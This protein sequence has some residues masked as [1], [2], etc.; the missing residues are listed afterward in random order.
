MGLSYPP[1]AC[2]MGHTALLL[3]PRHFRH[4]EVT[5]Q[6]ARL[7]THTPRQ[8]HARGFP[9]SRFSIRNVLSFRGVLAAEPVS[10]TSHKSAARSGDDNGVDGIPVT[11]K[12]NP[13]DF[14]VNS[15]AANHAF[16]QPVSATRNIPV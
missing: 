11:E 3:A 8:R 2:N 13:D 6:N 16:S 10:R 5:N 1:T 4:Q 15:Y 14:S 9:A 12:P 7:G